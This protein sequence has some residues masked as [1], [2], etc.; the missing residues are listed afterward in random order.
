MEYNRGRKIRLGLFILIG[1]IIFVTFFYLVGSSS[2]LFS[3][4]V[5]LH[6]EF[7]S[8]SG[9]RPGDHVRFSGIIIGT[10]SNLEITSDTSVFVDMSIDRKMLKF[11]RKDSRVE[12]KPE[13]L[14]GDKM[15]VI[16]SGTFGTEH[17]KEGDFLYPA[18]SVILE[19]VVH[20]LSGE[21]RKADRIIV[22]L[23]Q[24]SEKVNR[25]DGNASRMINDSTIALALEATTENFVAISRNLALLSYQLNSKESDLGK[26]I[27]EDQLTT[28]MDSILL[29]LDRVAVNMETVSQDLTHTS[30]DLRTTANSINQGKGTVN[31]LLN[32]SAFADTLAL[33]MEN[34]NRAVQ[35]VEQV[36][37][38]LQSKKLFGGHKK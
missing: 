30:A 36:A 27:T 4:S 22:N 11:I 3:R 38:N 23:A 21:L 35:E 2:K 17:V 20:Q 8:V 18:T 13:A 29:I 33:T 5:L 12:I 14:I 9:L 19:D 28:R 24:I 25:G 37:I 1:T 34:L 10:V 16:Y 31:M 6:T 15:L 32:D 7:Q 26:L